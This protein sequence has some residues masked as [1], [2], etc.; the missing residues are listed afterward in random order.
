MS[1]ST[2][3]HR[4]PQLERAGLSRHSTLCCAPQ[5]AG[6]T[7]CTVPCWVPCDSA[8]ETGSTV[9]IH[10]VWTAGCFPVCPQSCT[11]S[12]SPQEHCPPPTHTPVSPALSSEEL[13]PS[14]AGSRAHGHLLPGGAA[15]EQAWG[16][17]GGCWEPWSGA[18]PSPFAAL[19]SRMGSKWA[20]PIKQPGNLVN[21]AMAARPLVCTSRNEVWPWLV[22]QWLEHRV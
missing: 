12:R 7:P 16:P 21:A 1:G 6:L 3:A 19:R 15:R 14:G 13:L 2:H 11:P 17:V 20:R 18:L 10:S 9:D 8:M 22:A 5:P 4:K